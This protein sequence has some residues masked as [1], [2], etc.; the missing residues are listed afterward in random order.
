MLLR[1]LRRRAAFV[2]QFL[3]L[4]DGVACP[5]RSMPPAC[6][7]TAYHW[8]LHSLTVHRIDSSTR[9]QDLFGPGKDGF[10]GGDPVLSVP[11]TDLTPDWCNDVQESIARAVEGSGAQLA[12]G[13]GD[14]LLEA[15]RALV[16]FSAAMRISVDVISG[17]PT[18]NAIT[19]SYDGVLVAVGTGGAIRRSDDGGKTWSSP[20]PAG[21]Y[22]GNFLSVAFGGGLFVAVGQG[23]EIQTSPDGTTWTQRTS[24]SAADALAVVYAEDLGLWL[25]GHVNGDLQTSPDGTTWT[26]QS[27][28][29][30]VVAAA[31][32]GGGLIVT[33]GDSGQI[34]TSPD[35]V[36]WTAQ[37]ADGGYIGTFRGVV[38]GKGRFVAVGFSGEIQTSS[39]GV[40]WASHALPN[41]A[42]NLGGVAFAQGVFVA[43]VLNAD[44]AL[45]S[46]DGS[47]WRAI[48]DL[49]EDTY[50]VAY[51]SGVG[52]FAVVG[53]NGLLALSERLV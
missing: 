49:G 36:N 32:Y 4:A 53:P 44:V 28:V 15:V 16:N 46:V 23:G 51:D 42:W 8:R 19:S 30:S 45:V 37:T 33:V 12:K 9:A 41:T 1:I 34:Q 2:S 38:H 25:V 50:D 7:A 29:S 27:G 43:T 21:A 52:R 10:T 48:D 20:S 17:A 11:P 3:R 26:A 14:Q 5:E 40:V 35:G 47:S 6:D 18:L 13:H 31:A 24:T 39:D 22:S